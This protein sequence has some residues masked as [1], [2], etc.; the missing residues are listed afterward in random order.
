MKN[1]I[2]KPTKEQVEAQARFNEIQRK[3]MLSEKNMY[4]AFRALGR[5][6]SKLEAELHFALNAYNLTHA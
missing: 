2:K 4:F 1:D 5:E 6:P 3:E